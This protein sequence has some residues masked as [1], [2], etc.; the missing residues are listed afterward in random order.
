MASKRSDRNIGEEILEGI[1]EIKR[2]DAGRI[3][4]YPPSDSRGTV[5]REARELPMTKTLPLM[6]A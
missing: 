4:T 5:V 1:R 2:G 3:S 6:A